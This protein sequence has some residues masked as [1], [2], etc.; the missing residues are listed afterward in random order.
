[1][2]AQVSCSLVRSLVITCWARLGRCYWSISVNKLLLRVFHLQHLG[3]LGLSAAWLYNFS[4]HPNAES[5]NCFIIHPK[6]LHLYQKILT[7]LDLS[8][9]PDRS[10]PRQFRKIQSNSPLLQP[11]KVTKYISIFS[12]LFVSADCHFVLTA[13]SGTIHTPNFP[14]KHP[15]NITC[16]W[17]IKVQPGRFILLSFHVFELESY[18]GKCIDL[19]EVKDGGRQTDE[20]LGEYAGYT[21]RAAIIGQHQAASA[22]NN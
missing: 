3:I 21:L 6:Y 5:N 20:L 22:R 17:N 12:N 7:G 10:S 18:R 19:V 14:G 13:D 11:N 2:T 4:Y 1:M 8:Q 15:N 9:V 16:I